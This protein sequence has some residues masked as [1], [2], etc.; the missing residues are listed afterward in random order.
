MSR[1]VYKYKLSPAETE[2]PSNANPVH[3][4]LQNGEPHVWAEIYPELAGQG[5]QGKLVIVAVPTGGDVPRY[6]TY[7]GTL[8]LALGTMVFHFYSERRVGHDPPPPR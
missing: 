1:T 5:K 4:A 6:A 8:H 7:I 3:V 2:L